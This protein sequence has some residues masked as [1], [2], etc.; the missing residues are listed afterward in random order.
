MLRFTFGGGDSGH[1]IGEWVFN[2]SDGGD[3][4]GTGNGR[5]G[6]ETAVATKSERVRR[7]IAGVPVCPIPVRRA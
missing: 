7:T 1:D 6:S 2:N 4:R 3:F 5:D